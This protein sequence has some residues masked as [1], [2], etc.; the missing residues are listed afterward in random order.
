MKGTWV[1]PLAGEME[2]LTIDLQRIYDSAK[3][4]IMNFNGNKLKL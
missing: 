1:A 2:Q 4:V 3:M